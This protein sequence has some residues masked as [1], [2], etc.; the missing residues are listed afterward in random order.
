MLRSY[1]IIEQSELNTMTG[2][3]KYAGRRYVARQRAIIYFPCKWELTLLSEMYRT[4]C[5]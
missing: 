4:A 1:K 2:I 5:P 3:L